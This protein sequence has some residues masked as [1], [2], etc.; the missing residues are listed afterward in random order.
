VFVNIVVT[1]LEKGVSRWRHSLDI[2]NERGLTEE[3]LEPETAVLR[4]F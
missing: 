4:R 2:P 1:A 3:A